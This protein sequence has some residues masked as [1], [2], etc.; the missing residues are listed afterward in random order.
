MLS[1]AELSERLRKGQ[2]SI[3]KAR[4]IQIRRNATLSIDPNRRKEIARLGGAARAAKLSL[5]TEAE[6]K[7]EHARCRPK[8]IKPKESII[9][10]WCG[11]LFVQDRPFRKF[12][13]RSCG[14]QAST[15]AR[16]KREESAE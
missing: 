16:M 13:S 10:D 2:L 7:A 12:C 8:S 5:L 6:R 14:G 15:V 3:P 11:D 4:R 1:K 9:C